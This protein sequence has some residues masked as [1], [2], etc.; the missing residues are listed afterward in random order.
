VPPHFDWLASGSG[1][2]RKSFVALWD[3]VARF[4]FA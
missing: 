1:F 2:S 3:D 4:L